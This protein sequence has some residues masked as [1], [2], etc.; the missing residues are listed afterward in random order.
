MNAQL[1]CASH[2]CR[3]RN[4]A[5]HQCVGL[6]A[7]DATVFRPGEVWR[8][9]AGRPTDAH[10]GT[11]LFHEGT[12]Y[13]YGENKE[14]RTWLPESTRWSGRLLR[15]QGCAQLCLKLC[16]KVVRNLF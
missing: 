15:N 6:H 10:G 5:C 7:D 16:I 9:A 8:D 14:G 12:Y 3:H 4:P 1:S 13:W 2:C 11:M